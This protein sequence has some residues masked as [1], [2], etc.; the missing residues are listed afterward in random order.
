MSAWPSLSELLR[1]LRGEPADASI[2][3]VQ[4]CGVWLP[5]TQAWLFEQVRWLPPDVTSHVACES[6]TNLDAFPAAH[7]HAL[8]DEPRWRRAPDVLARRL[9]LRTHLS[10][11]T[12]VIRRARGQLLHSHF[13]HAGWADRGAARAARVPHV[14]TF[15][16]ADISQLPASEPRWRGRYRELFASAARV[17]CEGPHMRR[18]AIDLGCPPEKVLVHHLGV[19]VA[20]LPFEPREWS[21]DEPLRV[22]LAGT[23]REKKGF[24]LALRALGALR[25]RRPALRLEI[26]IIG[27]AAGK[28]G[29]AEEKAAILETLRAERLAPHARLLGFQPHDV[30]TSEARQHHLFLSPSMTARDGDT[31]GGAPVSILEMAASGMPV[32]STTHCDIPNIL[33]DRVSGVLAPE[34]DLDALISGLEW[35]VDDPA[36]WRPL[37]E[38]ARERVCA[39]FDAE[40]QGQRLAAIYRGVSANR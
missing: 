22:L 3:V 32:V 27:D 4:S 31:E 6:T 5:R 16:G 1:R 11:L 36:R 19:D 26:T 34:R 29:D 35:L 8:S 7:L 2:R 14:V 15:Y 10:F 24:P 13:G 17:L 30:L 20:G 9:R 37:A 33:R 23:F 39:S 12:R 38:A 18:C 25:A 21:G 40:A 28:P